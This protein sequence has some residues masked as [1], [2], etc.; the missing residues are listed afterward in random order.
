MVRPAPPRKKPKPQQLTHFLCLPLASSPAAVVQWQASLKR[1]RDDVASTSTAISYSTTGSTTATAGSPMGNH[2]AG[3][4][5]PLKAIRPIATLHLTIGVMS[6]P[7][8]TSLER[9]VECLKSTLRPTSA[10]E[11]SDGVAEGDASNTTTTAPF[12]LS[13]TGLES[14][15]PPHST[16]LLY[17]APEDGEGRLRELC[18]GLRKAF[19]ERG[20]MVEQ[21]RE[22]RLHVTVVNTV[23]AGKETVGNKGGKGTEMGGDGRIQGDADD[24]DEG[25]GDENGMEESGMQRTAAPV[26]KKGKR[27]KQVIKFDARE[28]LDRYAG[29]T[30]ARDVVV[31]KVA[32]CEMGAKKVVDERTGEV[33]GEEYREVASVKLV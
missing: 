15:H 24:G 6:L 7:D 30:W 21:K 3:M 32:I 9:A 4:M 23:Y 8:K 18:E 11:R 16:S 31:E 13:F 2:K 29:F 5:I 22:M 25:G 17:V 26:E 10:T 28:L 27:K 33:V 14:M 19:V 12:T 1:L 20:V